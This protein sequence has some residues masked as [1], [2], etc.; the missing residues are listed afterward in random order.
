[1]SLTPLYLQRDDHIVGLARLLTLALCVLLLL[2]GQVRRQLAETGAALA[3]LYAGN[4]KRATAKPTAELLL[5]GLREITLSSLSWPDHPCMVRH[6]TPL[7]ALQERI[8][9]LAGFSPALYT[10][11]CA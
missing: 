3:G 8:V 7:T 10:A 4:P 5:A 9:T 2:E 11:L 6:V 1:M